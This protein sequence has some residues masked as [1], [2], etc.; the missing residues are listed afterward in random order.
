MRQQLKKVR[1]AAD[2]L[3][4]AS[5]STCLLVNARILVAGFHMLPRLP[6]NG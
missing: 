6:A 2:L 5:N 1:R 4:S 3:S